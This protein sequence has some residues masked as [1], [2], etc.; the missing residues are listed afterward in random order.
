MKNP[1]IHVLDNG[2]Y[3]VKGSFDVVDS[4]GNR[5]ETEKDV[6]LCRCGYSDNK[7]FCDGTHEEID[8]ESAPRAE[9]LMVE[10]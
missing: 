6:S 5:F 10:V 8:F 9:D 1:T 2:P 3:Q 7:P 4:D